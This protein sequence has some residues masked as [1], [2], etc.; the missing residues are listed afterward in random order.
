MTATAIPTNAI[1]I[2]HATEAD[3][4]V[5]TDLAILDSRPELIGPALIAEVAGV[6]RAALDLRDGSVAADPFVATTDLVELLRVHAKSLTPKP[7]VRDALWGRLATWSAASAPR[8]S[9]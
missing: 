7:S 8:T 9:G 6:P 3:S 1:V 4:C 2:R 5:L